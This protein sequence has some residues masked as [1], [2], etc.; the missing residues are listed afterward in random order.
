MREL[1]SLLILAVWVGLVQA[2][3]TIVG[4]QEEYDRLTNITEEEIEYEDALEEVENSVE[5]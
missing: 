5:K 4:S 3:D 1:A 2:E